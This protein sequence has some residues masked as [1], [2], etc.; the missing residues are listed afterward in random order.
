M[1]LAYIDKS[2]NRKSGCVLMQ[3]DACMASCGIARRFGGQIGGQAGNGDVEFSRFFHLYWTVANLGE[4]ARKSLG[5]RG[6]PHCWFSRF[7]SSDSLIQYRNSLVVIVRPMSRRRSL[8]ARFTVWRRCTVDGRQMT[9]IMVAA[10][11]DAERHW[12]RKM[13]FAGLVL[14]GLTAAIMRAGDTKAPPSPPAHRD[15][16]QTGASRTAPAGW[17]ARL[18]R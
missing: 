10:L 3:S 13:I 18:G 12:M 8:M 17:K 7:A 14:A 16:A 1:K 11:S 15:G 5:N 4:K 9:G 2:P 6:K